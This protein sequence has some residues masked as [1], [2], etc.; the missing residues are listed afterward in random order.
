[1]CYTLDCHTSGIGAFCFHKQRHCDQSEYSFWAKRPVLSDSRPAACVT[2]VADSTG[3]FA[4]A[5]MIDTE[6]GVCGKRV[7]DYASNRKK[8]KGGQYYC[9]Q[10]CAGKG[11]AYQVSVALGGDVLDNPTQF[12]PGKASRDKV[13]YAKTVD[14]RR[15]KAKSYYTENREKILAQK[16]EQVRALKEE[17]LN[18]YGGK[19]EC[20]GETIIEFLTIDHINNDGAAHRKRVGKGKRIYAD[21]KAQGYPE[22]QYRVLCFNCNISRGFYGYCPHRP[23]EYHPT[24]K[25]QKGQKVGRPRTVG[26]PRIDHE[27]VIIMRRPLRSAQP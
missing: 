6:C 8:C 27:D 20:C 23:D 26:S 1:M 21:I 19:C 22:G 13:H 9:S 25:S 2:T 7:Y 16:K 17:V 15:E 18:T 24:D 5:E 12:Q 3:R 11:R 10:A 4:M 14:H